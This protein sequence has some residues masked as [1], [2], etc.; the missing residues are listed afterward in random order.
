MG[1]YML[2]DNFDF[3]NVVTLR[4]ISYNENIVE[5]NPEEIKICD[6]FEY[7]YDGNGILI[8]I[9][10][11]VWFEPVSVFDIEIKAE[12]YLTEIEDSTYD[13]SE[14]ELDQFL[15]EFEPILNH[16]CSKISSIISIITMASDNTPLITPP[17]IISEEQ[18]WN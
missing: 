18:S 4:N 14:I 6:D 9:T 11:K 15:S 10:R 8:V 3:R 2:L 7:S 17:Q 12:T 1:D 5:G 13:K 16:M